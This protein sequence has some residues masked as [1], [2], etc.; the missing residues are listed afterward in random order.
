MRPTKMTALI[1]LAMSTAATPF[2]N[3]RATVSEMNV[4]VEITAE[5]SYKISRDGVLLLES[6]EAG[7]CG[8]QHEGRWCTC[9]TPASAG[10]NGAEEGCTLSLLKPPAKSSRADKLG[11]YTRTELQWGVE[12]TPG[13]GAASGPLIVVAVRLYQATATVVFEQSYP[14]GVRA[15]VFLFSLLSIKSLDKLP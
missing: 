11:P 5:G 12:T 10:T 13:G 1:A 3:D 8:I 9:K 6:A 15:I 2:D 14:L 4:E 7:S